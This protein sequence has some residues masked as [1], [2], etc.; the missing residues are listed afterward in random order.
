MITCY[1]SLQI[2]NKTSIDWYNFV[3]DICAQYFID[4]PC[5]IGGPGIEVEID[6]SKFGKRKYNRARQVDGHWVF[7]GIERVSGECFLVEVQ[8]RDANTLLPLIAQN[9]R[10]GSIVYS[11]KWSSYN[12][13]SAST[14]LRHLTVSHSLHF[15]DPQ[16]HI[17]KE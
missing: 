17:H 7:G 8:Q 5:V 12:P 11:D 1:I 6:K 15:V 14:W 9:I 16:G 10:P 2:S 13:L 3:R 4:H